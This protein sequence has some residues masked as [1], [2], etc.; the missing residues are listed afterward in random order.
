[1]V[2]LR[3]FLLSLNKTKDITFNFQVTLFH[4]ILIIQECNKTISPFFLCVV[5]NRDSKGSRRSI[6]PMFKLK[7]GVTELFVAVKSS[8]SFFGR[9][10]YSWN[11][12]T[13]RVC[14]TQRLCT[15][16]SMIVVST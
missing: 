9:P 1:M 12:W 8:S 15:R 10:S 14:R 5:Y 11:F 13:S 6:V 7:S 2:S 16:A 3:P 4:F